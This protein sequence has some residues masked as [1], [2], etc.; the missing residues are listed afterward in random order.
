MGFKIF[1]IIFTVTLVTTTIKPAMC[2]HIFRNLDNAYNACARQMAQHYTECETKAS[3][4]S[5]LNIVVGKGG[6]L[7]YQGR[8][9]MEQQI[10]VC[11]YN[12][13][14]DKEKCNK[15]RNTNIF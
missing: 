9:K 8:L 7:G 14:N 10:L 5:G 6:V 2:R 12:R 1:M 4:L 3:S 13:Q 15:M 11:K